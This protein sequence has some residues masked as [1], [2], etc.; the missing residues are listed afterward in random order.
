MK[1]I[2]TCVCYIKFAIGETL[3]LNMQMYGGGGAKLTIL[4]YH[5]M[6]KMSIAFLFAFYAST[7]TGCQGASPYT[8]CVVC[9]KRADIY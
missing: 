7:K 8:P 1:V 9:I 5:I 6:V 4:A 2:L 3:F